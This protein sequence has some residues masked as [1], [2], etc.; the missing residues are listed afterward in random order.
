MTISMN[1]NFNNVWKKSSS[2]FLIIISNSIV[3]NICFSLSFRRE[4]VELNFEN[5]I[6][7]ANLERKKS[8][9]VVSLA[10]AATSAA[11]NSSQATT[12][13]GSYQDLSSVGGG[14]TSR[15]D[16]IARKR[17]KSRS[18]QGDFRIQLTMEQ[19]LDIIISEYE[20]QKNEQTRR[21]I[22]NEKRTD[23]LQVC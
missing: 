5:S 3:E 14:G 1:T 9:P 11:V 23:L 19:K 12:P 17:S 20:Q 22:A 2:F 16:R 10:P 8:E 4:I 15:Q 7:E 13:T 18:T 6:F 21:Q